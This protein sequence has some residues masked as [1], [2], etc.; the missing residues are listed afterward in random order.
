MLCNPRRPLSWLHRLRFIQPPSTPLPLLSV[1]ELSLS[2]G[3]ARTA[4]RRFDPDTRRSCPTIR[5][6]KPGLTGS[7]SRGQLSSAQPSL[8]GI[9][10]AR[11]QGRPVPAARARARSR[12]D[13]ARHEPLQ[14]AAAWGSTALVQPERRVSVGPG[15]HRRRPQLGGPPLRLGHHQWE[16]ERLRRWAWTWAWACARPW[17]RERECKWQQ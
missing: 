4:A 3:S 7:F 12:L 14:H 5:F 9:R 15:P 13:R 2:R 16:W 1:G 6:D 8:S 17:E 10:S 11:I